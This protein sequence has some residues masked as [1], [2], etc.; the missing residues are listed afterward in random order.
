[1][2]PRYTLPEMGAIWTD[3]ARFEHMLRVEIAVARAE[4]SRGMVPA[5]AV[6]AIEARARVD[7]D[8]IAEIEKTTDH[9]V[10]AFVSQV[11][12]TVGEEG[13]YLH[14]GLTSSDVVD[15]ALGLQLQAA[16]ARLIEDVD[17][18]IEA[19]VV[20][21][22][23]EAN[24]VMMG[25]T[26]SVHAELT[27]MGMKIAGWAFEIARDRTRLAAT[28][29]DAA[30][31]KI[32]GPVGTYSH[33]DP[34]LEAEVLADLGLHRDPISTQIVQRDR[35]AALIAAIAITGGSLERIATEIRNLQHTE[36]GE[37]MEPFRAGQKGSSAMP[38][39]R[40]PILCERI[41]GMARLLR[42]YAA[43]AMENQPL[44]HER[45]IS[46]SSAER[47]L[48]PDATILLDYMLVKTRGL[49]ERLVVHPE[50]MRENI[51]RGLGLHC[52]GR[53]LTALVEDAG[54]SREEAY[55]VVQRNA[56]RAAD[57]RR[58][59]RELL[60]ADPDVAARLSD[61]ALAA[62]FDESHILRNV[63]AALARLDELDPAG[64]ARVRK[65][66]PNATR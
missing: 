64:A 19:L 61:E 25:R 2:I 4:V 18:L 56:L 29:D 38:H 24:T 42:G 35:H 8:R 54:L 58:Q 12:E 55:A 11:A 53:V 49:I 51:E 26:H 31:G 1:M 52:S 21:A 33:L 7:V 46:H 28:A 45:D 13:R 20:R 34:D 60:A 17:A 50:R 41:A 22:R 23:A 43:A 36:I 48:L 3:Q 65:K 39:K 9:D 16:G 27:T 44:W 47:V 59:L 30:T 10:I 32:S 62:C 57:E 63:P 15:T 40:N 66:A 37:L 5:A 6:R 14:L